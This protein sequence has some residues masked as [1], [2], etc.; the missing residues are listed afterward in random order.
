MM[1]RLPPPLLPGI[2][3]AQAPGVP[4]PRTI[5]IE[6]WLSDSANIKSM[7]LTIAKQVRYLPIDYEIRGLSLGIKPGGVAPPGKVQ[8]PAK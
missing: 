8:P 1:M 2:A 7:R 4:G 3:P 5:T 6:T